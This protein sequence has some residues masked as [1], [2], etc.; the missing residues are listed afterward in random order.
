MALAMA[1][2]R[3]PRS[4]DARLLGPATIMLDV[5]GAS[6]LLEES[7]LQRASARETQDEVRGAFAGFPVV[8]TH[9][10]LLT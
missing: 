8:M 2:D 6:G 4:I 5:P 10:E 1:Q 7:G 3:V 9:G